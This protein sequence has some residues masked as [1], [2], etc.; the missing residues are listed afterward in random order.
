MLKTGSSGGIYIHP[1]DITDEGIE[2]CFDYLD[3]ACGLNELFLAAVYHANTFLLPHNPK[4]IV[5]WDDGSMFFT[6]QHPRWQD[7][8]IQPVVGDCVDTAGYLHH[9]M[10]HARKRD[11]GVIFFVVFHYSHSTARAFPEACCVDAMGER[12][13]AY[14]CPANPD[15][16][17]Y[18]LA[19]VEELMGT[20]GGDG[21]RHES[22]GFSRWDYG[23]VV[24]KVDVPPS[25]RDQ[26]LLSLCFCGSCIQRARDE[27]YDP[28]PLRSEVRRHL[29]DTLSR[30]PSEW[31]TGPA[32]EEWAR[33]AF[34]DRLWDYL[35]VR[36]HTV[37]SLFAAVQEVV[38]RYHGVFM[39]FGLRKERSAMDGLDYSR[40][41]PHFKR[42][43]VGSSGTTL[44]EKRD[45]L[46]R[47]IREVP[48]WAEPEITHVQRA[49]R[50]M[51]ALR[52]EVLTAREAGVRHHAFHYYG[53]TPRYQL[54]WIGQARA[55]W[56]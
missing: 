48:E 47:Q 21:I 34:D 19:I 1:W 52:D 10:D 32:D 23:V 26:L 22:L 5:R 44:D 54:E 36:C 39:P 8:R 27:G 37:T 15:V 56:A 4:R 35:N 16:R 53:M 17:A 38:N 51:E 41:Y 3:T 42:V 40:L 7:T 2:P 13:R 29:Y 20:Y 45:S 12:H 43:S 28:L 46:V 50:T 49:F 14:L 18:D 9:I 30:P 33:H 24:N 31:D 25:R 55:A 11:W 6:P